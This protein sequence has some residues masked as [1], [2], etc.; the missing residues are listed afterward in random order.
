MQKT[1]SNIEFYAPDNFHSWSAPPP[2][3]KKLCI[4]LG[5]RACAVKDRSEVM[6]SIQCWL[7]SSFVRFSDLEKAQNQ[8]PGGWLVEMAGAYV[9]VGQSHLEPDSDSISGFPSVDK[10]R[11]VHCAML[12]QRQYDINV[13]DS[14]IQLTRYL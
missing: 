11:D 8:V 13:N 7:N 14:S 2:T 5:Q 4:G 6:G 12:I 9:I 3:Q 10:S 1:F